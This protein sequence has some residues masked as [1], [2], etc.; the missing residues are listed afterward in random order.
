MVQITPISALS[1]NY[2]WFIQE[3]NQVIIVDP[4]EDQ[5]V[6]EILKQANLT[7]VAILLTHN[8]SDHTAG[9]A[10]I[11]QCYPE[12]IVYGSCEVSEFADRIVYDGDRIE[13][14]GHQF[15]VFETAGHTAHH[16]SYLMDLEH[17]FCGDS[18]FS[19]GCGRVF[20]GD[21]Q[22]QF[23][24]LQRFKSLPDIV[25]VYAAHEYTLTNLKFAET[26]LP[27]SCS[28]VEYQELAQIKRAQGKPT[29]PSTIGVEMQINPFLKSEN[30]QEFIRLRK[31]RD[32]F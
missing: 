22:A 18:L 11:K 5:K 32:N 12:L 14:L 4:A 17:L 21:Y 9:V 23:A 15:E 29:L 7:P 6:L 26:V 20:T 19:A 2:I 31:L 8:H 30:L 28:F 3:H 27:I 13:L 25:K 1:D 24:A 16:I 10:G